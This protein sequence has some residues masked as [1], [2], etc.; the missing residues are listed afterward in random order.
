MNSGRGRGKINTLELKKD[1]KAWAGPKPLS[2]SYTNTESTMD[3]YLAKLELYRKPVAKDGSCLFRVVSEQIYLTQAKHIQVRFECI[4]FMRKNKQIFEAFVEGSYEHH[5]YLLK[6]PKEWGGQVEIS[7]LSLLYHCDFIVYQAIHIAPQPVTCN[8]FKKKIL[9][10]Y[11]NGNHYDAVYPLTFKSDAAY[12]QSLIY[13]VILDATFQEVDNKDKLENGYIDQEEDLLSPAVPSPVNEWTEVKNKQK[14]LIKSTEESSDRI[15]HIFPDASNNQKLYWQLKRSFD[16]TLY[17]NIELEVWEDFRS[18]VTKCDYALAASMQ[19]LKAGDLCLATIKE[20]KD[21]S[22]VIRVKI[23][24]INPDKCVVYSEDER[25]RYYVQLHDLQ[26]LPNDDDY[27][28]LPGYYNKHDDKDS[29]FQPQKRRGKGGKK[30]RDEDIRKVENGSRGVND[31]NKR[32]E[33]RVNGRRNPRKEVEKKKEP[34]PINK[35]NVPNQ[36]VKSEQDLKKPEYQDDLIGS[37]SNSPIDG[38]V[39]VAKPA[40]SAAAFWGRMRTVKNLNPYSNGSDT[41]SG[42][43]S[44]VQ[45]P[46]PIDLSDLNMK[47]WSTD[48]TSPV[49]TPLGNSSTVNSTTAFNLNKVNNEPVMTKPT[50]LPLVPTDK[51]PAW[52][53]IIKPIDS[54]LISPS[55]KNKQFSKEIN[56]KHNSMNS[57]QDTRI[58]P[59]YAFE[60]VD[61]PIIAENPSSINKIS[62]NS[63]SVGPVLVH[64]SDV[65]NE[66]NSIEIKTLDNSLVD[67]KPLLSEEAQKLFNLTTQASAKVNEVRGNI[68]ASSAKMTG[69]ISTKSDV[70]ISNNYTVC[71]FTT[72]LNIIDQD[73]NISHSE[74]PIQTTTNNAH[75]NNEIGNDTSNTEIIDPYTETIQ[76]TEVPELNEMPIEIEDNFIEQDDSIESLVEEHKNYIDVDST[77][78]VSKEDYVNIAKEKAKKKVSFG[79]TQF[80]AHQQNNLARVESSTTPSTNVTSIVSEP[81]KIVLPPEHIEKHQNEFSTS[82]PTFHNNELN[83]HHYPQQQPQIMHPFI[84]S[85]HNIPTAVYPQQL[86]GMHVFRMPAAAATYQTNNLHEQTQFQPTM[87]Y[88]PE[89]KD[90]PD[91][92]RILQHY[93]NLGVQWYYMIHQPSSYHVTQPGILPPPVQNQPVPTAGPMRQ[94]VMTS[95]PSM[96]R[97]MDCYSPNSQTSDTNVDHLNHVTPQQNVGAATFIPNVNARLHNAVAQNTSP[98]HMP[99]H[100]TPSYEEYELPP[101]LQRGGIVPNRGGGNNRHYVQRQFLNGRGI[102]GQ[103][104]RHRYS[105]RSVNHQIYPNNF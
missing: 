51:K 18:D 27:K 52:G 2:I 15:I 39:K 22:E 23:G 99:Q 101:R 21:V 53:N 74:P 97:T 88:D 48:V 47:N 43:S 105:I 25:T 31:I 17:R 10:C 16:T 5:L 14:G 1:E 8:G 77:L 66:T 58:I 50:S 64:D 6:N 11:S 75:N 95:D 4:D 69:P 26:P 68:I 87:S 65:S 3:D 63:T 85:S 54:P 19:Q 83:T 24:E 78:A 34:E 79:T 76:V 73:D 13:D 44:P 102:M 96:M 82:A 71:S 42:T 98:G 28:D 20:S 90:L 91:E 104:P 49:V 55:L 84:A 32:V 57:P 7:A 100:A 38:P 61:S 94:I 9:L 59:T 56:S 86:S 81:G 89:G 41:S 70:Q 45:Q 62:N 37:N 33:S 40:E 93:Y 60:N 36:K 92:V 12:C 29:E 30:N 46:S 67:E 72:P 80:I 103:S 35:V